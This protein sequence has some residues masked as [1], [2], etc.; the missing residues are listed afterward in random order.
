MMLGKI[1]LLLFLISTLLAPHALAQEPATSSKLGS[2]KGRV[3]SEGEAVTNA[4]VTVFSVNAPRQTRS[5]PTNDNGDFEVKALEPGMYRVDVS[6]PAY[7]SLPANPNEEIHRV[8]DSITVDM[9]RGG[10][11]T[12]KVSTADNDPVVAIRVR[13]MMI[14]DESGR[15]PEQPVQS[16][17]RLTDDRGAYRI[18]GLL[19]GTYI[20]FAG[21]RGLYGWGGNAYDYDAPSFAPASTRDTAEEIPLARG[22]EQ[23]VD[24]RYRGTTGHSVSGNVNAATKWDS[25]WITIKLERLLNSELDLRFSTYVRDTKGFEFDGVAGGDYL[26]WAEHGSRD[27]E[28]LRSEP[29]RITVKGA[30]V[31]GIELILRP[32]ASVAGTVLL[33]SSTIAECK[34]KARPL[35]EETLVSIQRNRKQLPKEG[36]AKDQQ[37][38]PA[39]NSSLQ[40]SPDGAGGFQLRN[41]TPGQYNLNVRFFSKYWYLRSLTQPGARDAT[42]DLARNFLTLNAGERVSAVKATLAEGASA[43]SGQVELPADRRPGGIVFY[44]VPAKGDKPDDVLRH[45]AVPVADDGSFSVDHIP[46]GRYRTL[47][48]IVTVE[49]ETSTAA[50]R[51][52]AMA[53]ARVRLRR[54]AEDAKNEIELKP[55]QS[56]TNHILP[57]TPN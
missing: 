10:V 3:L 13:A 50:L 36:P 34:G 47:A 49:N 9:I 33:E 52:P 23:T 31:T 4:T 2:I 25:R 37:L 28:M 46:P 14:R 51:L 39:L 43:I 8:G 5:V 40:T 32:L 26:V 20:V 11:I 55:C 18:F 53:E 24:I 38:E 56:V 57:L 19:P 1:R 35:F 6:A 7:V 12:G 48:K 29:K 30:D 27:R 16:F 22:E 45:F 15:R 21:G 41:L 17:E 54:E 44:L 42:I